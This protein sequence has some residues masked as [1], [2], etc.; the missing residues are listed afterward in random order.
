MASIVTGISI[1]LGA[2]IVSKYS[3]DVLFIAMAIIQSV[4]AVYQAK[5]LFRKRR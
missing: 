2:M 5:I 3:F 4:A 1:L